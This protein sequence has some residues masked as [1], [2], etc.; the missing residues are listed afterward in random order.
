MPTNG[1]NNR[2]A[3]RLPQQAERAI[4][5]RLPGGLGAARQGHFSK[6]CGRNSRRFISNVWSSSRK[7]IALNLGNPWNSTGHA[8]ARKHY[9]AWSEAQGRG[10]KNVRE[11]PGP[12]RQVGGRP[13]WLG[14]IRL[15]EL[16]GAVWEV[17]QRVR[18]LEP[19]P[20]LGY[21]MSKLMQ[22]FRQA[23]R[24]VYAS[25]QAATQHPKQSM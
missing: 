2:P 23:A 1:S 25:C 20:Q 24:V 13:S 22:P 17:G 3:A 16:P 12:S 11:V 15:P 21:R 18:V 4:P 14:L 19:R 7:S 8:V 10:A 5:C 9:S 6:S